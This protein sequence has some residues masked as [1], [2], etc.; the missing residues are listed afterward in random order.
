VF[1]P[2]SRISEAKADRVWGTGYL[3]VRYRTDSGEKVCAFILTSMW[4]IWGI[5]PGKSPYEELAQRI[6]QLR[7]EASTS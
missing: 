3:R 2:L 1:L 7:R 6:E 4:T 5:I